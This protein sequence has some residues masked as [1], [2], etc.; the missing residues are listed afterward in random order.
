MTSLTLR[1]RPLPEGARQTRSRIRRFLRE[2]PFTPEVDCWGCSFDAEFSAAL[3]SAGFLG[4]TWPKAHGG[5]ELSAFDRLVVNEELLAAGAPVAAHWFAD[6]QVGPSLLHHGTEAQRRRFLPAMAAGTCFAAIGLSE[7]EAGS[8][9]ASVRTRARRV[10]GGWSLSGQKVWTS[11]AHR[12]HLIVVL[13]RTSPQEEHRHA[14]L[15]QFIVELPDP[16]VTIRPLRQMSGGAHINEVFLD[17]VFVPETR[18]LGRIGSGW[19]QITGEL[20]FERSGPERFLSPMPLL[21]C[22]A[23]AA[24]ADPRSSGNPADPS[25]EDDREVRDLVAA[26]TAR[27]RLLRQASVSVAGRLDEGEAP[28]VEAAVVKDLGT[29]FEQEFVARALAA[30][31][32]LPSPD[33]SDDLSRHLGDAAL[34]APSF[35]LRGGA[36]D[37]LRGIVAKGVGLR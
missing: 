25:G 29:S 11:W 30:T 35:T 7:P 31:G 2:T 24:T 36:N 22:L 3:G 37:I 16:A 23:E 6:R 20:A 27:L 4:M 18:V 33:A 21:S 1:S 26:S 17:E 9:L 10:S 8:D 19:E 13:A 32:D 5:H 34:R 14:G 12:S 28:E 15:S